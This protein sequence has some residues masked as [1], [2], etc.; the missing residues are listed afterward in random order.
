MFDFTVFLAVTMRFCNGREQK[1]GARW[2]RQSYLVRLLFINKTGTATLSVTAGSMVSLGLLR[3][4]LPTANR[5]QPQVVTLG[6]YVRTWAVVVLGERPSTSRLVRCGSDTWS[7]SAEPGRPRPAAGPSLR[8][9]SE[10][11]QELVLQADVFQ[12]RIA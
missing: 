10:P 6:L 3:T 7:V 4:P 5:R 12:V 8:R 2:R 9:R 1:Q 11:E